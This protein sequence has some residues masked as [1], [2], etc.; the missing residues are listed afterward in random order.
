MNNNN[1]KIGKLIFISIRFLGWHNKN[2]FEI[3]ATIG[4]VC[5]CC[6]YEP[7]EKQHVLILQPSKKFNGNSGY[8]VKCLTKDC[9]IV[10]VHETYLNFDRGD[11]KL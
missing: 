7:F 11:K 1:L 4:Q 5:E 2:N 3:C 9:K 8:W 10:W 6:M